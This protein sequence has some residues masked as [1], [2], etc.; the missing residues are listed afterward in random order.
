MLGPQAYGLAGMALLVTAR[1][2]VFVAESGWDEALIQRQRI[3]PEHKN[4][5]FWLLLTLGSVLMSGSIA[6]AEPAAR[7]RERRN[8]DSEMCWK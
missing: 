4:V 5:V 3:D 6:L 1:G 2:Q 8:A 7:E